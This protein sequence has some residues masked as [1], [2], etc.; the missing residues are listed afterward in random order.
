MVNIKRK[1]CLIFLPNITRNVKKLKKNNEYKNI[2]MNINIQNMYRE[3]SMLNTLWP[4][5]IIISYIYAIFTG[6]VSEI[7]ESIFSSTSD[8]VQMCINLL[9]NYMFMEWNNANRFKNKYN[10]KIN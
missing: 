2:E 6:K 7:N 5:F 3:I 4:F 1:N 10:F 9:R 8:A